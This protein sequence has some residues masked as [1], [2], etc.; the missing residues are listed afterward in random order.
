MSLSYRTESSKGNQT[1]RPSIDG[2]DIRIEKVLDMRRRLGTGRYKISDHLDVVID[3]IIEAW[4]GSAAGN[5][6]RFRLVR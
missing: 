1:A 3:R 4:S 6:R 2:P 5:N